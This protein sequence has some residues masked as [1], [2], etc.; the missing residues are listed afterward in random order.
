MKTDIGKHFCPTC[1]V[2]FHAPEKVTQGHF[3]IEIILYA[4]PLVTCMIYL[5]AIPI[6]YTLY[7]FLCKKKQCPNCHNANYIPTTSPA[8]KAELCRIYPD[9]EKHLQEIE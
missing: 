8:A 5:L 1:K 2:T 7:R 6:A 3:I 4:I 9:Y